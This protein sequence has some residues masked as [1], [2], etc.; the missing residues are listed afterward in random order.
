MIAKEYD[1]AIVVMKKAADASQQGKDFYKLAQIHTERQEWDLALSSVTKALK[2]GELNAEHSAL[3]LKGLI[4]FNM[5]R[6]A[7]AKVEFDKAFKFEEA[8]KMAKQWLSYIESEEQRRAYMA[9]N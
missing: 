3:I 2:L 9:A 7:E 5:D 6:L 4:L 1:Q 8:E